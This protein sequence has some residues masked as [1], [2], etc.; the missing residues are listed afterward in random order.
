MAIPGYLSE[1]SPI[2]RQRAAAATP[3]P[4][5]TPTPTSD[6]RISTSGRLAIFLT[7]SPTTG[8]LLPA[9]TV[10]TLPT[11]TV[12]GVVAVTNPTA[13]YTP[14]TKW[15]PF[16]GVQLQT[17][18]QPGDVVTCSAPAGWATVSTGN[19]PAIAA[20]T[21]MDNCTGS[22]ETEFVP[23]TRTMKMGCNI[24]S[25]ASY[26]AKVYSFA[27][28]WSRRGSLPWVGTGAVTAADGSLASCTANAACT[29]AVANCGVPNF[30]DAR[31]LPSPAGPTIDFTNG[32]GTGAVAMANVVSG[33]ISSVT[34]V[35]GG[36]G[37]VASFPIKVYGGGGWNGAG[38]ANVSGGAVASVTMTNGGGG[39][40]DGI[41]TIQY[42][43]TQPG[44][45]P[46]TLVGSTVRYISTPV[47]ARS[48]AGTLIAGVQTGITN[49]Y[50]FQVAPGASDWD[51]RLSWQ[52]KP[53]SGINTSR[54]AMITGPDN[55][56]NRAAPYA[57]DR[58][59]VDWLTY[60][61]GR[62]AS[63]VRLVDSLLGFGGFDNNIVDFADIVPATRPVWDN[64][65]LNTPAAGGNR[66]FT[67]TGF[68]PFDP[69]VS[70]WFYYAE[71]Y[72]GTSAAP[73]GSPAPW[74]IATSAGSMTWTNG[75]SGW[76][77]GEATTSAPHGL[78][79]GVRP[80]F[81]Q[82]SP[83]SCP[84]LLPLT[85]GLGQ[86]TVKADMRSAGPMIYVTGASTF[87]FVHFP[88]GATL[89]VTN[90]GT[91]PGQINNIAET[92]SSA[93]NSIASITRTSGGTGYSQATVI[94]D[95]PT[96]VGGRQATAT[97]TITGGV[98]NTPVMTDSG[99]GYDPNITI[100]ASIAGNGSGAVLSPKLVYPFIAT[101]TPVAVGSIPYEV[102]AAMPAAIPG[103]E[104]R[105]NLP[106][107]ATDACVAAIATIVRDGTPAGTKCHWETGN[108]VWNG[109][110]S[111]VFGGIFCA[112]L[113]R[114]Q[115]TFLSKTAFYTQLTARHHRVV[116]DVFAATGRQADVVRW[117]GSFWQNAATTTAIV[118]EANRYNTTVPPPARPIRIDEICIAPYIQALTDAPWV[119]AIASLAPTNAGSVQNGTVWPWTLQMWHDYYRHHLLY[120]S[121]DNGTGTGGQAS[122]FFVQHQAALAAYT[123][124]AGQ[125]S[126][127]V[128]GTYEGAIESM[129]VKQIQ[130]T[131]TTTL[132]GVISEDLFHHPGMYHTANAFFLSCQ[133]G[134]LSELVY[135][136]LCN[137]REPTTT[138]EKLWLL[139][140]SP[141]GQPGRGDG[142][143]GKTINEFALVDGLAH[144]INNVSPA[145]QAWRDWG[146]V[147]N[148]PAGPATFNVTVSTGLGVRPTAVR[149]VI[150][151]RS[152]T[153]GLQ[154]HPAAT[155]ALVKVLA[156]S[157]GMSLHPSVAAAQATIF[158]VTVSAGMNLRPQAA[159]AVDTALAVTSGVG[160]S[161]S[162]TANFVKAF[163]LT[164]GLGVR[165]STVASIAPLYSL[166]V[167]ARL[168]VSPSA[169]RV[170]I[171]SRTLTV[172]LGL[173]PTTSRNIVKAIS[174]TVGLGLR[175]AV[176]SGIAPVYQLTVTAG[177]GV[178]A[179]T[180]EA[181]EK[182]CAVASG[183]GVRAT[184][185]RNIAKAFSLT[186]GLGLHPT[187][188]KN[189]VRQISLV[190]GLQVMSSATVTP[191]TIFAV[192]VSAGFGLQAAVDSQS[193]FGGAV[194]LGRFRLGDVVNI[195]FALLGQ[196]DIPEAT[197]SGPTGTETRALSTRDGTLF[198]LHEFLGPT[199]GT[200]TY[201]V[202]VQLEAVSFDVVAGGDPAGGVLSLYSTKN[203][204]GWRVLAQLRSGALVTGSNPRLS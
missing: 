68:R 166:S 74:R 122:S 44:N 94:I 35:S 177:F 47:P 134:G 112:N 81:G 161:P 13:F 101:Y 157:A 173:R 40:S 16:V 155:A 144:T 156:V 84:Q 6:N 42:D 48:S 89:N 187:T 73:A 85:N 10:P 92:Q 167:T 149:T 65:P 135:Y 52:I 39:Y 7:R 91:M 49:A 160:L 197:I 90:S 184:A 22:V 130:V 126:M 56:P 43:D 64:F 145:L 128:L 4:T 154:L 21:A 106:I 57:P 141:I 108:E 113:G 86:P 196:V 54:N 23:A 139:V 181:F 87:A 60:S 191:A 162:A 98:V 45:A 186:V 174:L 11:I 123:Q 78:V 103:C 29:V 119:T 165:P 140:E 9:L 28:D 5:P 171:G 114:Q 179:T 75:P 117:F 185:S 62:T 148:G 79:S 104:P 66:T 36:T 201:L 15:D 25:V 17:A 138:G 93:R 124:V 133:N 59:V 82:P 111:F 146:A 125:A 204:Q 192:T 180:A 142:S 69:T 202:T 203:V 32:S 159:A 70:P 38:T 194:S 109:G 183:L 182:A 18:V 107:T 83:S 172:G 80:V 33:V 105:I 153:A 76:F 31:F 37:Y 129:T 189:I 71:N 41:W 58:R 19:V 55:V 100:N 50:Y 110:G 198:E 190:T 27:R 24:G 188:A 175:P 102:P 127:P 199:Y 163:S 121:S 72:P 116:E 34:M 147:A 51:I 30:V 158:A 97:V 14:T 61:N 77:V 169:A 150:A 193:L 67:I 132:Q 200:G 63:S 176:A 136:A 88:T 164:V 118:A 46:N 8:A 143:D 2:L 96:L 170:F 1:L 137:N 20:G 120:N 131:G 12:N 26:F 178:Q 195:S 151:S 53:V 115:T 3:T 95:A 99:T 168:G 152:V